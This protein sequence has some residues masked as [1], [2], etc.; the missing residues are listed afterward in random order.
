LEQY[1][2]HVLRSV[3]QNILVKQYSIWKRPW[4]KKSLNDSIGTAFA[5]KC[6]QPFSSFRVAFASGG[7]EQDP[8]LIAIFCHSPALAEEFGEIDFRAGI[9]LFHG[10]P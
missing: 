5:S 8:R 10:H 3:Q 2:V 7:R 9:S 4:L 6:F 1:T